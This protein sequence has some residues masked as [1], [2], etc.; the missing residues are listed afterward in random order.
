[1][2][3]SDAA[4]YVIHRYFSI[5]F[6]GIFH[7]SNICFRFWRVILLV[8]HVP[9]MVKSPHCATTQTVCPRRITAGLWNEA[10]TVANVLKFRPYEKI[11]EEQSTKI[12]KD[13]S[14][15]LVLT[16]ILQRC[17]IFLTLSWKNSLGSQPSAFDKLHARCFAPTHAHVPARNHPA[18]AACVPMLLADMC[19]WRSVKYRL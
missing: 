7:V 10:P 14:I 17:V 8:N 1:M 6:W 18:P 12:W 5:V 3:S 11:R 16:V 9:E 13:Q 2:K 19:L 4:V 15:E